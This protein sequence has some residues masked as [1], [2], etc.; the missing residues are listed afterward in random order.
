MAAVR[1]AIGGR[2]LRVD[3][4][5][6]WDPLTAIR[7]INR[8]AE[9]DPEFVEQPTPA[10]A[11]GALRQVKRAVD[12]PIAADQCAYTIAEVFE[13]CRLRAA[14]LLVLGPHETGGL[15]GLR[16][17]AAIAEAAGLNV[18][19]HG[20]QESGITTCASNQIAATLPNLDDGNQIMHQLLEEDLVATPDLTVQAG[21]LR[22]LEGPGLGFEINWDAVNRAA[23]R[24]QSQGPYRP[25]DTV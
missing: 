16:K 20:Q 15:L 7:I 18:C 2:R 12:V 11:I 21:K 1:D 10:R 25:F 8:F 3:A 5:E 9:F 13:V 24:Y 4:N 17:A 14:D 23:E 6:A 19:I 22:A